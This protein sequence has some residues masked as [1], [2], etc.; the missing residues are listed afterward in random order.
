MRGDQAIGEEELRA[1][2]RKRN[3]IHIVDFEFASN[4]TEP[5]DKDTEMKEDTPSASNRDTVEDDMFVRALIV[6]S[7]DLFEE[8]DS[9]FFEEKAKTN[10]AE[11]QSEKPLMSLKINTISDGSMKKRQHIWF[12]G[13]SDNPWNEVLRV[14]YETAMVTIFAYD[15]TDEQ[16]WANLQSFIRRVFFKNSSKKP[17]NTVFVGYKSD[18]KKAKVTETIDF[19]KDLPFEMGNMAAIEIDTPFSTGTPEVISILEK[20]MKKVSRDHKL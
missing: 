9:N 8:M 2:S 6:G 13:V 1:R 16:S 3:S 18:P 19:S 10:G 4:P 15:T 11:A 20:N 12:S 5:E 7:N 14:Y 17:L